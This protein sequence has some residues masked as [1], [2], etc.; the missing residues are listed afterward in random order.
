L[1]AEANVPSLS[2]RRK[3]MAIKYFYRIME[4][5]CN[6]ERLDLACKQ[7]ENIKKFFFIRCTRRIIHEWSLTIPTPLRC[8]PR[9]PVP[10]WVSLSSYLSTEFGD[11]VVEDMSNIH[12]K[13]MFNYIQ[14]QRYKAFRQIFTDG[15]RNDHT[16]SAAYIQLGGEEKRFKLPPIMSILSSELYAIRRALQYVKARDLLEGEGGVVSTQIHSP[17]YSC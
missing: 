4:N 8:P 11:V 12:A 17:Q 1:L 16:T 3:F 10:P 14:E 15:S 2:M 13:N 5:S 7:N 6:S 9:S